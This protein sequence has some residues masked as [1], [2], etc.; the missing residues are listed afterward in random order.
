MSK[1]AKKKTDSSGKR[2]KVGNPPIPR[3]FY[4][5]K[6]EARL[7]HAGLAANENPA[8]F[9]EQIYKICAEKKA[10]VAGID[11][12]P[13][14]A[15][16]SDDERQQE[17][18]AK[19]KALLEQWDQEHEAMLREREDVRKHEEPTV[20]KTGSVRERRARPPVQ[21]L[22]GTDRKALMAVIHCAEMAMDRANESL[23]EDPLYDIVFDMDYSPEGVLMPSSRRPRRR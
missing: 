9:E 11:A 19:R 17:E 12:S 7:L 16:T 22:T 15:A 18:W 21:T 14:F 23:S 1:M 4:Q 10:T 8:W 6:R 5:G 2:Y 13:E 20:S 3:S